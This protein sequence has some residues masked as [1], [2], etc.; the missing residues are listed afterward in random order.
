[1]MRT[2]HGF[3]PLGSPPSLSLRWI[4]LLA[5]ACSASAPAPRPAP[6]PTPAATAAPVATVPTP[7]APTPR[8]ESTVFELS[9]E[10][11]RAGGLPALRVRLDTTGAPMRA[12]PTPEPGKFV[13]ASGPPGGVL[14][15]DVWATDAHG[16]D[17]A[18]VERA[19]RAR[20]DRP[21]HDPLV[22]GA[23]AKIDLAGAPR[24]ALA[25]FTG[26]DAM[27]TAWCAAIVP[28]G[29]AAALVT[30]GMAAGAAPAVSCQEILGHPV[31]GKVARTL[32]ISDG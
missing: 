18:A 3:T 30:I 27:R 10:Q 4:A 17:A 12:T 21:F 14:Q 5:G 8:Q 15:I 24:D 1:M 7:T 16:T 31:L 20:L 9:P 6:E 23:P 29:G 32:Q 2:R 26:K 19:V 25:F 11:A 22:L 13:I 28:A